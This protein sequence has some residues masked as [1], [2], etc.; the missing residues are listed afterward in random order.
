LPAYVRLRIVAEISRDAAHTQRMLAE[1]VTDTLLIP[2]GVVSGGPVHELANLANVNHDLPSGNVPEFVYFRPL[3][4][5]LLFRVSGGA[6]QTITV[7]LG[8]PLILF[9]NQISGDDINID[10][11]SGAA[12]RYL[13]YLAGD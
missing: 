13:L 2:T 4:A 10:N 6:A 5:D 8:R 1:D 12:A 11:Q 9:A 3:D 7:P